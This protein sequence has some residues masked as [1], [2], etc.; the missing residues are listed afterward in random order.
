MHIAAS[1]RGIVRE[2]APRPL[3]RAARYAPRAAL[4]VLDALGRRRDP[5]TPPRR[6]MNDG[7]INGEHFRGDGDQF[8]R[9]FVELGDLS[10]HHDVLDIGCGIGRKAVPLTRHLDHSASYYGI[11][12]AEAGVKWCQRNISTRFP[13]FNFAHI[14]DPSVG[15]GFEPVDRWGRF[16]FHF[17]NDSFDFVFLSSVFTHMQPDTVVHYLRE[18]A[19]VLR[20]DGTIFATYFLLND[21]SE[22]LISSGSSAF[23]FRHDFVG[24]RTITR[25]HPE[26]AIAY[27]ED[28]VHQMYDQVGLTQNYRTYYGSWPGRTEYT[29]FQDIII[30]GMPRMVSSAPI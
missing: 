11:D 1:I 19:R 25:A 5:L 14:K 3:A 27:P 26:D 18:I 21:Q 4:D 10:P 2:Y 13:N 9:H 16:R 6:L 28:V 15:R 22:C 29:S 7:S 24:F 17:D 30:A 23:D 12:I 8:L 20:P